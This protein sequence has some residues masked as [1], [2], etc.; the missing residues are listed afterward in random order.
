MAKDIAGDWRLH[1]GS[2]ARRKRGKT[3]TALQSVTR[4]AGKMKVRGEGGVGS[5]SVLED[6]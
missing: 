1:T 3:S 4:N 5:A 2:R 6:T